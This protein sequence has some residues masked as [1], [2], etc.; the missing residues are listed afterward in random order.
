MI[1]SYTKNSVHEYE[2]SLTVGQII[3]LKYD[4]FDNMK[5]G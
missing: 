4:L 2:K 5:M 3:K 1:I